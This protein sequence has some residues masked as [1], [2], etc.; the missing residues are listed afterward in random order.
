[1]DLTTLAPLVQLVQPNWQLAGFAPGP[2]PQ[3]YAAYTQGHQLMA[4]FAQEPGAGLYHQL[5]RLGR[6]V[7]ESSYQQ[8]VLLLC[9]PPPAAAGRAQAVYRLSEHHSPGEAKKSIDCIVL[10]PVTEHI[11]G[12]IPPTEKEHTN[13]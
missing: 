3:A 8:V 9:P 5:Y 13:R 10:G 4:C 2:F 6:L 11:A 12:G 7:E 1:M